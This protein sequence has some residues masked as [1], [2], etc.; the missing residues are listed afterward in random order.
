VKYLTPQD[1]IQIHF[2]IIE[3]T[4][5]SHGLR[6]V[7]LLES[8]IYRIQTTFGGKDLYPDVFLKAAALIHS[9]LLNHA[10]VDENKRTA[11]VCTIIFLN[12]NGEKFS[13]TTSEFVEFPIWI[14]NRKPTIEEIADWLK[15]HTKRA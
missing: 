5:G 7:R 3:E 8:A 11:I 6:D 15:N 1:V 2:E 13:A 14:E 10:F 4:G 12:S 9:L